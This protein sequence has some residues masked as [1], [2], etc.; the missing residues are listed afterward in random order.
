MSASPTDSRMG[1]GM[2]ALF[3]VSCGI[4]AANLYY[5]QPLLP[6]IS[7]DLHVGSG[8][9]ALVITA[10]Q[11][12]YG[13][14][15]ALI[16]PLGD[17]LVRRRL[18]PGIL[19][20][21][22]A[23]LF[24]ASLAPDIVILIVAVTIAGLCSVAAQILVPFA[25]SLAGD[26]ERGR[27]VGAVMSGLLLGILLARTFS[28][29]I[30]QAAGWRTVYVVAGGVVLV[31]SALLDRR[32][33][34]EDRRPSMVYSELLGSVIHLMR[35]EPLLRLRSAIGGLAFATFNVIWTSLAFLLAASPYHYG[36]AVIG[37]FGLLGAAGALAASFS[38]RLAD[39][40]LERWV[41]GGSLLIIVGSIGLLAIGAHQLWALIAGIVVGDLGIQAVHIQNQQLIF[42]IDP[43]AR[44]RLNTGYMVTYFIGG[45]VGS[46]TT[47]LAYA[48]DGWP[49]VIVLG[50]CYSGLGLALW[51]TSQARLI[52]PGSKGWPASRPNRP[53]SA[54]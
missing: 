37:L 40:G 46:A 13:I 51:L 41:T 42:G 47:G 29:L 25:A 7:R 10:A 36:E 34:G 32:L 20:V 14:G 8:Q 24:A 30:A 1:P 49:G 28:G 48:A 21:A 26:R 39:R 31:L 52:H 19:L 5:A 54:A 27:V 6:Q 22:A 53:P 11:I 18:V 3:A 38:G 43:S 23:A 12:G 44:S 4:S 50:A 15:L 33:P 45:A 2:V 17:I 9:V 16:V 35:T